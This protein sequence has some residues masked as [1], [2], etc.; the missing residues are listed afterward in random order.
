MQTEM[1]LA[2]A[3]AS[4]PR[5][6]TVRL[7]RNVQAVDFLPGDALLLSANDLTQRRL[8]HVSANGAVSK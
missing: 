8:F 6:V 5:S 3:D 4:N 2:N 7:D 1:A